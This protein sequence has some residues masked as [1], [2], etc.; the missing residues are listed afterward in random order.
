MV[1]GVVAQPTAK[2]REE[3]QSW[4]AELTHTVYAMPGADIRRG[5]EIRSETG[6]RFRVLA[7]VTNS[8][9]TYTRVPVE[10]VQPEGE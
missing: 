4:A 2:E 3:A 9:A 8:R 6:E 7:A 10:R 5:D 1:R